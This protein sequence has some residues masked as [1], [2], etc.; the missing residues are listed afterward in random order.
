[1][2]PS[3]KMLLL[4]KKFLFMSM[5]SGIIKT[6][7]THAQTPLEVVHVQKGSR[8]RLRFIGASSVCPL[9]V[10]IDNHQLIVI[11]VDGQPLDP[12]PLD[13]FI[14]HPGNSGVLALFFHT[15]STFILAIY[16]V[17]FLSKS[18]LHVIICISST[19]FIW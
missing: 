17:P 14:I 3:R 13:T 16:S 6:N 18:F 8:Y 9:Q 12:R 15:S 19:N 10:S 5:D 7:L 4:P 2:H 1:M 11:A